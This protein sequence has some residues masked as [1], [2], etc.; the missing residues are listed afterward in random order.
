MPPLPPAPP[1]APGRFRVFPIALGVA[2]GWVL[3]SR[4]K[5][6]FEHC[7]CN[8]GCSCKSAESPKVST[9]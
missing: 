6:L 4:R 2:V 3:H 1:L 7:S 8:G 5:Q 9:G